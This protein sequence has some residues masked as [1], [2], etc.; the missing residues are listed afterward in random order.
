[1]IITVADQD[2]W[3]ARC[4][5]VLGLEKRAGLRATAGGLA[6]G[7]G[8]DRTPIARGL[9]RSP[10]DPRGLQPAAARRPN[11]LRHAEQ[12]AAALAGLELGGRDAQTILGIVDDYALGHALRAIQMT[13]MQENIPSLPKIDASEFPG[14]GA[15]VRSRGGSAR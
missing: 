7:P 9:P 3:L 14:A 6:G 5:E 10:V 8:R 12:S 2:R 15:P 13:Q 11:A 4:T 1:V